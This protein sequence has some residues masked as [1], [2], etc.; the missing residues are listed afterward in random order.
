MSDV[1]LIRIKNEAMRDAAHAAALEDH[2]GVFEPT[3][4]VM[5]DGEIVGAI[6]L[7]VSCA[8]W[9]MHSEKTNVMDSMRVFNGLDALMVESG[10]LQYHVPCKKDSPY[11][12]LMQRVGFEELDDF[13]LFTRNLRPQ[14][15]KD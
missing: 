1:V 3:H 7:Q 2:D 4:L 11:Y 12:K 5:K 10:K 9:W 14:V 6:S 13:R 8:S 15:I